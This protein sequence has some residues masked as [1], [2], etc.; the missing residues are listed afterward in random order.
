MWT[1]VHW[2][3]LPE[4]LKKDHIMMVPQYCRPLQNSLD[5]TQDRLSGKRVVFE[6]ACE[7]LALPSNVVGTV[8]LYRRH[9]NQM[10]YDF[11]R[12]ASDIGAL[13]ANERYIWVETNSVYG[14]DDEKIM[15]PVI[16][17]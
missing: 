16:L 2:S 11:S 14:K 13:S 10:V 1:F 6:E 7:I 9:G 5:D 15:R 12:L 3:R 4:A 8:S 17:A